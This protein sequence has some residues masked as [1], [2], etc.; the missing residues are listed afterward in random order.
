M[1]FSET[2]GQTTFNTRRVIDRAF[3]RCKL[4]PQQITP[5]YIDIAKDNLFLMLQAWGANGFLLWAFDRDI[6]PLYD[7]QSAVSTGAGT[8][9]I[10]NAQI[11]TLQAVTGTNTDSSTQRVIDFT[12]A[13]AVT[14][15]GIKW[16]ATA[17]PIEF[18]YSSDDV[19]YTVIQTETPSASAGEW[20]WYDMSA[21]VAARYFRIRA[22]SGT[23]DFSTITTGNTP[24]EIPLYR[25]NRDEYENIPNKALKAERP[26]QYWFDRQARTPLM[27]VWPTPNSTS[28]ASQIVV[29]R[30]RAVMDVGSLTQEVEVPT[31]W[32]DAVTAGLAFRLAEELPEVPENAIPRLKMRADEALYLARDGEYDDAPSHIVPD[33][34]AYTR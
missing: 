9:D 22:T 4:R 5:E 8:I 19:T 18:A 2:I 3:G 12:D 10:L 27:H 26:F 16:S 1:A 20:T 11:R 28:E 23:L 30:K 25:M 6:Y 7:G 14:T 34:S 24:S 13:T 15:V 33:I 29:R 32:Y 31:R 21:I 17:A